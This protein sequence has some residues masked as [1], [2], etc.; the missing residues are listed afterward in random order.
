MMFGEDLWDACGLSNCKFFQFQHGMYIDVYLSLVTFV[1][2]VVA[3][4]GDFF[5]N[6]LSV[7]LALGRR[8]VKL[9]VLEA[10][11]KKS[12]VCEWRW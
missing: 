1:G 4:F 10:V 2:Q 3:V 11:V 7:R 9:Y 6:S 8:F 5:S 12:R